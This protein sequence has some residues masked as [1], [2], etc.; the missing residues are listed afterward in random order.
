VAISAHPPGSNAP[1][2]LQDRPLQNNQPTAYVCQN[3]VCRQPTNDPAELD[4][5]LSEIT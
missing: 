5:Q 1:P 2:L 4:A 3:F